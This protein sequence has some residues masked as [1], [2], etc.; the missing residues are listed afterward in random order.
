M[1][2]EIICKKDLTLAAAEETRAAAGAGLYN[3][4]RACL[5]SRVS[6]HGLMMFPPVQHISLFLLINQINIKQM[7]SLKRSEARPTFRY[8]VKISPKSGPRGVKKSGSALV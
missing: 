8:D 6:Y 1:N 7:R 5:D 3:P 2:E 4:E